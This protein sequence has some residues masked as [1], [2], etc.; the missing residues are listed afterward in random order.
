MPAIF[1]N[2]SETTFV[3]FNFHFT[4]WTSFD[5][6]YHFFVQKSFVLFQK[7]LTGNFSDFF[8]RKISPVWTIVSG[9]VHFVSSVHYLSFQVASQT[10]DAKNTF[11]CLNFISVLGII[12]QS[13]NITINIFSHFDQLEILHKLVIWLIGCA[14]K[15]LLTGVRSRNVFKST[16]SCFYS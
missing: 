15:D 7:F 1:T 2:H 9:T 5:I 11:A 16:W 14:N 12:I 8:Q 6:Q 4:F 13:T 3:F 10:F